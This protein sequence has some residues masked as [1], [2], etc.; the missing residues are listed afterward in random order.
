M[1]TDK[2]HEFQFV[3]QSILDD[4]E[5]SCACMCLVRVRVWVGDPVVRSDDCETNYKFACVCVFL[6]CVYLCVWYFVYVCGQ[7]VGHQVK[8]SCVY[9]CDQITGGTVCA[10]GID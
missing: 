2:V 9:I 8:G 1:Y 10:A 6:M 7:Y 5:S 4:C 3:Q